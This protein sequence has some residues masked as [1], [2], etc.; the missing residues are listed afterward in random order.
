MKK[1]MVVAALAA[2]LVTVVQPAVASAEGEPALVH[3]STQNECK[4]NVRAG[5]DVGSSLLH[6]LTC[7]NYT[8]CVHAPERDLPCG[9][10]VT[11]GVYSCV[12]AD[13]KQLTD[14]RW[15]EVLWRSP[16]QSFVAVG[17]AAIR[18]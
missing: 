7:T 2:C 13:G 15:A 9:Q 3:A 8:T 14:N 18:P 11:G 1:A 17:C 12:G 4:L 6:T 10:L 5:A 16:Q